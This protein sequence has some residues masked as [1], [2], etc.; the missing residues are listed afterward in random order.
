MATGTFNPPLTWVGL[1]PKSL[2]GTSLATTEPR[3]GLPCSHYHQL[4]SP[5]LALGQSRRLWLSGAPWAMCCK[6]RRATGGPKLRRGPGMD[7]PHSAGSCH[8]HL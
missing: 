5:E 7:A 2:P 3:S 1:H 8:P 4:P 6:E